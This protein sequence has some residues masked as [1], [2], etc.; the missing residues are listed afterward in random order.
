MWYYPETIQIE[1]DLVSLCL[2]G[3]DIVIPGTRKKGLEQYK[4]LLRNNIDG[5][6]EQAFPIAF[7]VLTEEQ[8]VLLIDD[9]HAKHHAR[10]PKIWKL[11]GEFVQFVKE[12]DYATQ[13]ELPFLNDLLKFE[14]IETAVHTMENISPE[15]AQ[16]NGVIWQDILV[17]NPEMAITPLDYPVH[18]YAARESVNHKGNYFLLTY[19][20]PHTYEVYF[21]GLPPLHAY[22]LERIIQERLSLDAILNDLMQ[23]S[24]E[25][26]NVHELKKNLEDFVRTL[27]S[28]FVF[29]GF[30][31]Q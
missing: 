23:N 14:W 7:E 27:L 11:P 10:T 19:R 30:T 15:P 1:K 3:K 22:F 26:L 2:T 8:W 12:Q 9:F 31:K 20:H 5:T 24:P 28:E 21:V 25:L 17:V 4:K 13:L 29:L 16:S 18:L 6:M